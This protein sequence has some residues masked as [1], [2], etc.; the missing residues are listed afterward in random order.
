MNPK[1]CFLFLF[2]SSIEVESMSCDPPMNH[3]ELIA[4]ISFYKKIKASSLVPIMNIIYL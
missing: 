1:S 2:H 3:K 4:S